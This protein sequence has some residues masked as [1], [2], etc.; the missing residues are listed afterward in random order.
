MS[1]CVVIQDFAGVRTIII[2]RPAQR[3]ALNAAVV[4]ALGDAI[5]DATHDEA[6][7]ALV[8]T[9]AGDESFVAGADI[10]EMMEASPENAE[11]IA[12]RAASIHDRL[13]RCGKPLIAAVNG[14]CMGGGLEL[15]IAC[16]IRIAAKSAI[17][18]LPEIRL[19][20]IPGAGGATRLARI[21][22]DGPARALCM[23]GGSIDAA[24][25]YALGLVTELAEPAELKALAQKRAADIASFSGFA[26]AQLKSVLDHSADC[27][28]AAAEALEQKA[29][30]LC[31]ASPDQ[32]EGMTAFLEKRKPRF[33]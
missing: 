11:R 24:R 15:A 8:L 2:N 20:I 19:G 21:I 13:R 29:F 22:G 18:A 12:C 17:F 32:R 3:N 25:A 9:G 28:L 33:R 1:D 5:G 6:V 27:D 16:D 26:L 7:R 4:T 14:Y 31:F 10:A 30:A 23:T